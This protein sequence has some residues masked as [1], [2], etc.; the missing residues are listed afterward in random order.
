MN[1]F[2]LTCFLA[3]AHSLSFVRAAEHLNVTQP[4]ITHQI[5]SLEDELGV[6]LFRRS[7]RLVELT[8]EGQAFI[9]DAKNM[10]GIADQAKRRFN[11]R[12]G[13][14][15]EP[16]R[17]GLSSYAHFDIL[18]V[19][20]HTMNEEFGHFHPL[21]HVVPHE[22]LFHLLET[23]EADVV[24]AIRERGETQKRFTYRELALTSL[25]AVCHMEHPL[26]RRERTTLGELKN[27]RLILCDPFAVSAETARMQLKL[28][29]NKDLAD[30]HFCPSSAAAF[31]L[32]SAGLGVAVLPEHFIPRE[33]SLVQVPIE[34]APKISYG[35][36]YH[37]GN[38]DEVL[39]RFVQITAA[40]FLPLA[41]KSS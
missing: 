1:T 3:V 5:Q 9:S 14:R 11:S 2:Q 18:T 35:L 25:A 23:E 8:P 16:I 37:T 40:A 29:E 15:T 21:L 6:R 26:A 19:I 28:A 36:F 10:V 33:P 27:E 12:T 34:D 17:I 24:F 30:I 32:A 13:N 39:K 31:V 20:L 4:T 41:E 22:Q 7:T 38:D